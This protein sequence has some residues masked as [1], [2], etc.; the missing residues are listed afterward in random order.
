MNAKNTGRP[1]RRGFTL[2]ELVAVIGIIAIMGTI[3]VGGFNVIVRALS[4]KTGADDLRRS[5]NL[6]R[7][8]ACVD[9]KDTI[10]WVTGVDRYVVVRES[11][12]VSRLEKTGTHTF[13]FGEG[14][15]SKTIDDLRPD[16]NKD[17]WWIFDEFADLSDSANRFKFDADWSP[18]DVKA[19]ILGYKNAI[20]F[21]MDENV[22]ATVVVPAQFDDATE[23]WYFGVAASNLIA[24]AFAPGHD[25]GWLVFPEL[26]LPKG[27][28]FNG[29]W[30]E[31]DGSFKE[32]VHLFARF[33]PDGTAEDKV[34]FEIHEFA[35]K[36][37]VTV[38]VTPDGRI[39]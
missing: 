24:G 32:N 3:V 8:S 2:L 29:T 21:D 15:N 19:A 10:L 30:N 34:D 7:Q 37:N 1:G 22:P 35:T 36:Q 12:T 16:D 20:A 9:G 27:F 5:L 38:S 23:S 6:A 31:S 25:Y 4:Q 33:R 26:S 11:G 39:Q 17:V 28:A 18:S 13:T 14:E